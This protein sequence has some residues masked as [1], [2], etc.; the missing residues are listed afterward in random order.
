ML[1]NIINSLV[2]APSIRLFATAPSTSVVHQSSSLNNALEKYNSPSHRE[3]WLENFD[4]EEIKRLGLLTLHPEVFA[5]TPRIDIIQRN[6]HWQRMYRFVSFANS[7]T[8]AEKRGG[9]K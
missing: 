5:D 3:V 1:K 6:V 4:T 7:K 8:R 9:G 2:K